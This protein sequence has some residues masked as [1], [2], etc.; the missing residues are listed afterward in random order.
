[1]G[2]LKQF[3]CLLRNL[4]AGQ[5]ATYRT[6]YGITDYSKFGKGV[7]Q[8]CILSPWLFNLYA[9]CIMWNSRLDEVQA[10]IKISGRNTNNLRYADDII[11]MAENKEKLKSILMKVKEKSDR[12]LKSQYSNDSDYGIQSHHFMANR[13]GNNGNSERLCFWGF[14]KSFLVIADI[15][16]KDSCSLEEKLWQN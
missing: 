8:G 12:W 6:R 7:C 10:G 4:Y 2:I 13:W 14:P 3:T 9:E 5:E 11:V 1:M 15:K 16:L